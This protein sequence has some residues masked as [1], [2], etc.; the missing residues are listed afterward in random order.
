M[1]L[2]LVYTYGAR[3]GQLPMQRWVDVCCTRPAEIFGLTRKGRIPPGYDA[4]I[5]V[6]DPDAA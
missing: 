2:P 4:D 5:V 1:R 3:E 6:F